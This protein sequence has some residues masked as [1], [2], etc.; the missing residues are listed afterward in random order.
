[1]PILHHAFKLR[2]GQIL[3]NNNVP[4]SLRPKIG[5]SSDPSLSLTHTRYSSYQLCI[6]TCK[7]VYLE[8][9][10]GAS[11]GCLSERCSA[12]VQVCRASGRP[13]KVWLTRHGESEYNRAQKLGGD[14][15][16]TEA[17]RA[18]AEML[19]D[20]I[21]RRTPEVRVVLPSPSFFFIAFQSQS[22]QS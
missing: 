17:G 3:R 9:L 12:G 21:A 7:D 2:S 11:L 8:S 5:A 1:M 4:N 15:P 10:C 6:H 13:R 20:V 19:P 18:Y 22:N 14:A 16:L